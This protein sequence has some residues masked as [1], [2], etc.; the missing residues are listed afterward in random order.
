MTK[1]E[2][3]P[4]ITL[5]NVIQIAVLLVS[6]G[7]YYASTANSLETITLQIEQARIDRRDM[8][9]RMR[10]LETQAARTDER[11][12]SILT[13]MA[14]SDARQERLEREKKQ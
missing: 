13:F 4:A 7:A 12:A 14:R 1:P 11:F 5:G 8:D 2:F 6:V 3:S 10:L 9:I